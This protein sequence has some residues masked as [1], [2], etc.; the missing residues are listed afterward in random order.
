MNLRKSEYPG[1]K[2]KRRIGLREQQQETRS[3]YKA[4]FGIRT[5]AIGGVR[6]HI[7][8]RQE[9]QLKSVNYQVQTF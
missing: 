4:E 7:Q 8:C 2:P 9:R 3:A 1:K 6:I 5:R